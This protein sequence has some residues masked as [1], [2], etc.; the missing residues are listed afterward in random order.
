MGG[1]PNHGMFD[2]V[3]DFAE[4]NP[5]YQEISDRKIVEWA[6]KSGLGKPAKSGVASNDKPDCKFGLPMFDDHS[7]Q[8][9]IANVAPTLPRSFIIPELKSNLIESERKTRLAN[10]P[11]FKKTAVVVM[12]EPT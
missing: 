3:D 11:T 5:E 1:L 6:A 10:F 2:W 4:R 9:L 7:V 8:K 12:G